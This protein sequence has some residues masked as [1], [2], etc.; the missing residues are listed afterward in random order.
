MARLDYANAR[1]GARRARLL[2]AAGLREVL[3]RP[4]LEARIDLLRRTG[5]AAVLPDGPGP[6]PLGA[7][8]A[9]LREG[10]RREA[11]RVLAGVEGER[12]RALLAAFL[13]LDDAAAAKAALRAA[14]RG[15]PADR[16][17]AAAPPT[18]GL[19][20]VALR[21]AAEAPGLAQAIE[22]LAA[23]APLLGAALRAALPGS[24]AGDLLPIEVAADRAVV[25]RARAAATGNG[26]DREVLRRHL[27]DRVDARNAA[28]LLALAGLP[29]RADAF[30]EGG[31]R[32]GEGEFRALAGAAADAVRAAV[33]RLVPGGGEG[34][35]ATPWGADLALERAWIAPLRR[36]ARVRPLSLAVPLAYLAE[37]RAEV[38]RVALLL[39]G[40]ELG[41]AGD[42]LL[43]LV[44]A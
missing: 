4:S 23:A 38:R 35:L 2:G 42:E 44:E 6:D 7:C 12:P 36:E 37:R 29:P 15:T 19:P 41:L 34:A 43:D 28:T 21:A 32:L 3:A 14:A 10:W 11:A 40:A 26:E 20:E 22:R 13:G 17:L 25:A 1:L 9:A 5:L 27:G 18:P 16:A 8:E 30:L 39:R 33:A 24:A 31:R